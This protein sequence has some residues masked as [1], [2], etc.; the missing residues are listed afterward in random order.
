MFCAKM[1][2]FLAKNAKWTKWTGQMDK[3]GLFAIKR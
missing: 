1:R 2:V 3:N